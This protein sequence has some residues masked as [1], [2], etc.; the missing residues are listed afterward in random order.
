MKNLF[1]YH[2]TSTTSPDYDA[3]NLPPKVPTRYT[4]PPCLL[5]SIPYFSYSLDTL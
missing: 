1:I 2:L 3:I 5:I 4:L